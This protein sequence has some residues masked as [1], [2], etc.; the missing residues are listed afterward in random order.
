MYCLKS[1][2]TFTFT[3]KSVLYSLAKERYLLLSNNRKS[4]LETGIDH[5]MSR[6][7]SNCGGT[8]HVFSFRAGKPSSADKR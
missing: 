2:S 6:P 8:N 7:S 1:A 4:F 3:F 5:G